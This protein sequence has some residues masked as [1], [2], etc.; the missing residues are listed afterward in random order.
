MRSLIGIILNLMFFSAS[1]EQTIA[2]KSTEIR[3]LIESRNERVSSKAHQVSAMERRQGYLVRSFLPSLK[4]YSAQERFELGNNFRRT[5]P[6]YGAE[7]SVNLFNGTKDS[8]YSDVVHKRKERIETEKRVTTYE[9]VIKAKELY[10]NLVFIDKAKK[11]L[12]EI[13]T[14]NSNNLKSAQQRIRA[15]VTTSAD[16]FAFEIKATEVQRGL[17]HLDMQKKI[18]EREIVSLLGYPEQ[19]QIQAVDSLEHKEGMENFGNHTE[20]QHQFLAKPSLV[21]AEENHL[22]AKIQS[23]DRKS[24]V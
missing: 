20:L 23:R 14:V 7:V 13:L 8:L 21:Q 4:L 22:A 17:A 16:R 2:L 12:N 11:V 18:L 24:V 5:Q 3:S 9:E 10:W 15:G 6:T 19:T 1:A